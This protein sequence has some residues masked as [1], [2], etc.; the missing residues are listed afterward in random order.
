[1]FSAS[2]KGFFSPPSFLHPPVPLLTLAVSLLFKSLIPILTLQ[3]DGVNERL[4]DIR[5]SS[6]YRQGKAGLAQAGYRDERGKEEACDVEEC[7]VHG[8]H[9]HSH[10]EDADEEENRREIEINSALNDSKSRRRRR[11]RRK[12]K[13]IKR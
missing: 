10:G 3:N 4:D 12:Q 7:L 13:G 11:R 8:T 6:C 9:T 5:F 2:W 1:M